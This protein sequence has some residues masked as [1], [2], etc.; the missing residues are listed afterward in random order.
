MGRKVSNESMLTKCIKSPYRILLKARDIYVRSMTDCAGTSAFGG[1]TMMGYPA[2][3]ALPKSYSS[4]SSRMSDINDED[5]KEL[6]RAASQ[7]GL[8]T[9]INIAEIQPTK[10]MKSLNNNPPLP[11]SFTVG[12]GRIDEDKALDFDDNIKVKTDSFYPRSRSY[13]VSSK[14]STGY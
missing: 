11:R 1:T 8:K 7:R 9:K 3:C 5:F 12:I 6:I 14:R 2:P 10:S 4:S 13:A